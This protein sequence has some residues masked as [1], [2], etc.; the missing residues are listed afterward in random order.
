MSV[1]VGEPNDDWYYAEMQIYNQ[2]ENISCYTSFRGPKVDF[3]YIIVCSLSSNSILA[4]NYVK[5]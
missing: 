1:V 3:S 5:D 2:G 4:R